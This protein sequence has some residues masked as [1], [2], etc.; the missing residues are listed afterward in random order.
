MFRA[1]KDEH[2]FLKLGGKDRD[3][4]LNEIGC[5]ADL[6]KEC[7]TVGP[8]GDQEFREYVNMQVAIHLKRRKLLSATQSALPAFSALLGSAVDLRDLV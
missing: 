1:Y 5:I 8:K 3:Q 2:F 7:Q 4:F 6:A